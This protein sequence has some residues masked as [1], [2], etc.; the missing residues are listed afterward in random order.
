MDAAVYQQIVSAYTQSQMRSHNL[1]GSGD[2][3]ELLLLVKKCRS[4]GE[5]Q[6]L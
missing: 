6:L 5:T 4:W 1:G 2:S 3:L